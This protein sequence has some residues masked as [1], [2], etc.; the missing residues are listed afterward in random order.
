MSFWARPLLEPPFARSSELRGGHTS[1]A[2]E[3]AFSLG[4]LPHEAPEAR[5]V[6]VGGVEPPSVELLPEASTCVA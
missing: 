5:S 2:G 6:E 3:L 1:R 4:G